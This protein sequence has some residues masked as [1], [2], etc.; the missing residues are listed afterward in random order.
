MDTPEIRFVFGTADDAAR[1]ETEPFVVIPIGY[2]HRSRR[3]DSKRQKK[4]AKKLMPIGD[5]ISGMIWI[6]WCKGIE[7]I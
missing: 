5:E 1:P 7:R 4:K 2:H 3:R 6:D